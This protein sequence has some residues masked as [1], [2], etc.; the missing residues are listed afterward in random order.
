V[1]RLARMYGWWAFHPYDS[2]RST[3][4]GLPDLTL[5]RDRVVYAELKR[6]RGGR[7]SPAQ[8]GVHELLRAAGA[9]VYVWWLPR[10]LPEV[11]RV[12]ARRIAPARRELPAEDAAA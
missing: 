9:E 3:G 12:L 8:I 11:A 5:V 10:D 7:L 6:D 1:L 4:E 2:R